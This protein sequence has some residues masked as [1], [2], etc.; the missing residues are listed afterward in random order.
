MGLCIAREAMGQVKITELGKQLIN[1]ECTFVDV[2]F[3]YFLK[4]QLPNPSESG[5]KG[6]NINPF[7]ATLHVINKVNKLEKIKG[8]KPKGISKDEFALFIITLT[9]FKC[10]DAM[11]YRILEY[12]DNSKK[13]KDKVAYKNEL[14]IKE[15]SEIYS[16]Q[17]INTKEIDKKIGNLNDYADSVIRY[18]RQTGMIY[19]RGGGRYVDLSPTRVIEIERLLEVFDGSAREFNSI[20]EYIKYLS[21]INE[22]ILP[23]ETKE[24]LKDI[25]NNLYENVKEGIQYIDKVYPNQALHKFDINSVTLDKKED[26]KSI[27][28]KIDLLR[29]WM[30][31]LNLDKNVLEQ[32]NLKNLPKYIDELQLLAKRKKAKDGSGP[33]NLEWYTALSL[34][35]LDDAEEIK[36]NLLIGDDN[37]PLFTAPGKGA[38]IEAK[39]RD[40]NMVA[41]VTLLKARDQ[42]YAEGQPVMRHLRDFEDKNIDKDNYCLFIAP[43]LHRDTVN[44]FW[45]AI[46]MGY[47]GKKQKI[48]PLTIEQY[49]SILKYVL[50]LNKNNKRISS[51]DLLS[52]IKLLYEANDEAGFDVNVWINKFDYL[53]DNWFTSLKNN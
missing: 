8:N 44:T 42:W 6:F 3:R 28:Q 51:R 15:V 47:E 37:I 43:T 25:H 22:P 1:E 23:W 13:A 38:D 20:E 14:F 34:M 10:I 24:A 49:T 19:Y 32:R 7:I 2:M 33:L 5:F 9:D 41:E 52:L 36:P 16:I 31:L 27:N 53:I 18:F 17:E 30:S 29:E 50:E 12:R 35:A 4:W 40:F 21:N 11:V 26:N 48:V 46:K 45:M 39:Y